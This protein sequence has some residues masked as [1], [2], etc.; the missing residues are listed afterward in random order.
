LGAT[1]RVVA[2]LGPDAAPARITSAQYQL[3]VKFE[4]P[5]SPKCLV[6]E[7]DAKSKGFDSINAA[8]RRAATRRRA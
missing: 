1:A 7:S 8:R 2:V 3:G 6:D 5:L 4:F